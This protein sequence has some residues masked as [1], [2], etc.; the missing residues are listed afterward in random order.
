MSILQDLIPDTTPN[1]KFH[2][3]MDLILNGYV[4]MGIWNTA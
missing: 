1:H 2:M 3:N 4:D